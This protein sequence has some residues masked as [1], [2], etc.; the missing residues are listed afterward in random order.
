MDDR[1]SFTEGIFMSV[2]IIAEIGSA[3][4]F[5]VTAAL[6]AVAIA[7]KCRADA[8]K[9]QWTSDPREMER[10]R[11]VD[12]GAYDI[13]HYPIGWIKDIHAECEAQGIEFMCTVF[14]PKDVYFL[15]PYV[16]RW[17]VASLENNAN[18]LVIAMSETG[19]PIIVS[20]GAL[21]KY[22][23]AWGGG[24]IDTLHCTA[25]Y[26]APID[27]LNLMAVKDYSGYSD[28]SCN[29]LTGALAV[30]CGAKIV[31]VHFKLYSTP[32]DNPD[33]NHSLWPYD[34]EEYISNIRQAELMLG[35][36][37]KKVEPCEEWALKHRVRS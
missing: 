23:L 32:C 31:E 30:A 15:N 35:D 27:Q 4:T 7:K 12:S 20:H 25:A 9:F 2:F 13:L 28:H 11:N 10:R 24:R 21:A 6:E 37:I 14:L 8:I 34:L 16:K 33:Y 29:V 22:V 18:D 5:S 19:K 36:G 26:P 1:Q 17:K 3:W